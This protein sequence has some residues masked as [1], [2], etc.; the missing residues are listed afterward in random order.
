MSATV[1]GTAN[2]AA[3][4][5][6]TI[7]THAVGDLI[8]I[9]AY[10]DG[11][12]TVPSKPAASGT[13]PAWSDIDAPTGA[14]TNSARCAYF[15]ATATNHTSGTWSNATGMIAVVIQGN[16]SSSP[17]GGHAQGGS[18]GN[19]TTQA[20][21]IT[22][23][24]VTGKALLLEF[25][26]HRTVTAWSAAPSGY[27]R[28]ASSAT[29]VALNTKDSSTTDGAIS[30][31][32]SS[33]NSGYRGQT[34]EI[35]APETSP[36][37]ALNSPADAAGTSDST[38]TLNF[39]G[40]DAEGDDVRYELQLASDANF[41]TGNIVKGTV[42][43]NQTSGGDPTVSTVV[44]S[45]NALI[46][47]VTTQDSNTSNLGAATVIR[48][49]QSFTKIAE[50]GGS[51]GTGV[52]CNIQIWY[53]A[54]PTAGTFNTVADCNSS[55]NNCA[56]VVYP[57]AD[58]DTSAL[59]DAYTGNSGTGTPGAATI[60]SN[61]N[62][63]YIISGLVSEGAISGVGGG[64][65]TD[66]TIVDQSFE[67]TKVTSKTGGN[68]GSQTMTFT[69]ASAA[70]A[71]MTVA[72]KKT[73]ASPSIM[74]DKISGTDSGFSGSPDNSDPFASAQAVDFTVQAGDAIASSGTYYWRVRAKDPS[75]SNA[76]GAW[77]TARNFVLTLTTNVTVNPSHV[78]LSAAI[79]APTITAKRFV[80]T[81]ADQLAATG[82]IQA[83]TIRIVSLVSPSVVNANG[84]IQAPTITANRSVTTSP[85]HVAATAAIQA[86]TVTATR[87]VLASISVL[88]ALA[89]IQGPTVIT[90]VTVTADLLEAL[91]SIQAP[92][93]STT[94]SVT[95]SPNALTATITLQVP[96]ITGIQNT[97]INPAV[98]ALI[99]AI[100]A[101]T[102]DTTRF[103]T[104]SPAVVGATGQVQDPG[105]ETSGNVDIAA[106]T[107]IL[108][109]LIEDPDITAIRNV[110]IQV[111]TVQL[112]ADLEGPVITGVQNVESVVDTF[113]MT[114]SIDEPTVRLGVGI[115]PDTLTAS[116]EALDPTVT[117]IVEHIN[118]T[119]QAPVLAI[120]AVLQAVAVKVQRRAKLYSDSGNLYHRN[121]SAVL[122]DNGLNYR[123]RGELYKNNAPQG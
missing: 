61:T 18:T 54:S 95:V 25:Y 62:A 16:K 48:N 46:A 98:L 26:G 55:I 99:S 1:K 104:V 34:I 97:T 70:Y 66:A 10:R 119:I 72:I 3:T 13:V 49:G 85:S 107:E 80:T 19:G 36:T 42:G 88:D 109:G 91:G 60:T 105:I 113:E 57:L 101:P 59:I 117:V 12:T 7:P 86:P 8:V 102:V 115:S 73:T 121:T 64:Q 45:E 30:Q 122:T 35:L 29:E 6:V 58:C 110:T 21:S 96:V 43:S 50:Y 4:T 81:T 114:G 89:S 92:I 28:Q 123:G 69:A 76:Y 74:L 63:C 38:P 15:I 2:A 17:I 5:S 106:A 71:W 67:N 41:S 22:Q 32:C 52:A 20:P 56:M 93:I 111:D 112:T 9:W 14:N 44:G 90:P 65:D 78:A 27:T 31:A 116:L 23:Q 82:T 37:V 94:R 11:S 77:S 51:G 33:T 118:V 87:N 120:H 24:Q 47:I 53:L 108:L 103:V 100:Q 68:A 84:T 40:T 39:T 79:Q 75:G 83:P